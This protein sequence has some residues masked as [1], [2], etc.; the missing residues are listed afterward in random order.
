MADGKDSK[1]KSMSKA[2]CAIDEDLNEDEDFQ[3]SNLT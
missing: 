2:S 1:R 3:V